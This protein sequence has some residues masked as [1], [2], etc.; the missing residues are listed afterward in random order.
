MGSQT[1]SHAKDLTTAA[2]EAAKRAADH[3]VDLASLPKMT[4]LTAENIT[5]NVLA[6]N[7]GCQDARMKSVFENLV[8]IDRVYCPTRSLN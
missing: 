2:L 7:S 5:Q 4:D 3:T 8:S 1:P 6:I